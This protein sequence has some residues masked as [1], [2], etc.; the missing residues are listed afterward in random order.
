MHQT[1]LRAYCSLGKN[2]ESISALSLGD[3]DPLVSAELWAECPEIL[4]DDGLP[5]LAEL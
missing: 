1:T 3:A 4:E 5:S 2:F